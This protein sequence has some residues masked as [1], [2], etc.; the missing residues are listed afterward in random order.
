[1][2]ATHPPLSLDQASSRSNARTALL[3]GLAVVAVAFWQS[4]ASFVLA[5]LDGREQGFM[6]AGFCLWYIWSR[7]DTLL[8]PGEGFGL[9]SIPLA[10]LSLLWLVGMVLTA[11]LVHQAAV[12]P[13]ILGW[14]L[15]VAGVPAALTALPVVAT[16]FLI[17][18]FWG[19]LGPVLQA[20]TV[21]AN[22]A[23]L[24]MT[25][26]NAKIE[27]TYITIPSG[28]FEVAAGCSGIKYLESGVLIAAIYGLLFLRTWRARAVAI[29]LAA[30][31]SMISNWLRVVGLIIIGH[32]TEMQSPL[33]E[34]HNMYGWVIFAVTLSIFFVAARRIEALDD[35]LVANAVPKVDAAPAIV[36]QRSVTEHLRH[37]ALPTFAAVLGPVL[38]LGASL[39]SAE[40]SAPD[41]LTSVTPTAEWVRA[42]T[43]VVIK[44][45]VPPEKDSTR[46]ATE[47]TPQFFGANERR[48]ERWQADSVVVQ[49]DRIIYFT[50]N[51]D[52]ELINALNRIASWSDEISSGLLGPVD[53]QGRMVTA[54]IARVG[55]GAH[56]VWSW[57]NVAGIDT[58]SRSEAK[59]LELV[60]WMSPD[61]A[62]ELVT[63]STPCGKTDC[64]AASRA[65][66]TFVAGREPPP[67]APERANR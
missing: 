10:F 13:L 37:A 39:R 6:V 35:R 56:M 45:P 2:S 66:Y 36:P 22:A 57:F 52:R 25:D 65:L 41:V 5:W 59:L 67:D 50:Q 29:A 3:I 48:T 58:H 9:A 26:I 47:Y 21:M 63:V 51:Q 53:A 16:F 19:V 31:L 55:D 42:G 11:R 18:P 38:L 49:V 14:I 15:A 20:I 17:V 54:T 7:R 60:A 1:M 4:W 40:R 62:A 27:G 34:D 23:M 44:S 46:P 61:R 8:Q 12:P 33:I 28:V 43:P 32:R 24:S 64:S 30:I